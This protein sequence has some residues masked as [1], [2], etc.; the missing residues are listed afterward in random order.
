[1]LE[2][3]ESNEKA[4]IL[5]ISEKN[6][7]RKTSEVFADFLAALKTDKFCD[8]HAALRNLFG[9]RNRYA[10]P[11]P[12]ERDAYTITSFRSHGYVSEAD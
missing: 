8:R 2:Q 6:S 7:P 11:Q 1:M 4:G 5:G 10:M 3:S 12:A 9:F